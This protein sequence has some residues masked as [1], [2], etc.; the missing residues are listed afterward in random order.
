[1]LREGPLVELDALVDGTCKVIS[2]CKLLCEV[3]VIVRARV[4]TYSEERVPYECH[5][6]ARI[7]RF[8]EE[9]CGEEREGDQDGGRVQLLLLSEALVEGKTDS[10][11]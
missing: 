10:L 2:R 1:M 5:S 6:K 8:V 9:V 7:E 4:E 11:S 3:T